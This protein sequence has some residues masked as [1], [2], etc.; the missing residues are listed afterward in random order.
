MNTQ[1]SIETL[2]S[3]KS[4]LEEYDVN[5]IKNIQKTEYGLQ[6][7]NYIILDDKGIK[8]VLKNKVPNIYNQSI[9]TTENICTIIYN[10][11]KELPYIIA[12]IKNKKGNFITI[13]DKEYLL[14]NYI[15]GNHIEFDNESIIKDIAMKVALFHNL[16]EKYVNSCLAKKDNGFEY[17]LNLL[18]ENPQFSKVYMKDIIEK[19][20]NLNYAIQGK[21]ILIHGDLTKYNVLTDELKVNGI[22]DFEKVRISNRKE[23]V[24]RFLMSFKKNNFQKN[25]LEYYNAYSIEKLEINELDIQKFVEK[26]LIEEAAI[27]YEKIITKNS[28]KDINYY[29]TN[30]FNTLSNIKNE[31]LLVR[32]IYNNINRERFNTERCKYYI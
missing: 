17:H 32:K 10:I 13:N 21:S 28:A 18:L 16:S 31:K 5:S 7:K 14:F 24:I 1:I 9:K 6:N 12:P 23:E 30:L 15:D 27:W 26:D 22:I 3:I 25:F 29:K 20:N 4:V 11:S 2:N 8:Y 19:Y